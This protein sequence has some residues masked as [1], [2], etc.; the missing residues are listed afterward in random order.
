LGT[1]ISSQTL[2]KRL[3]ITLATKLINIQPVITLLF[4]PS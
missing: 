4:A 3:P 1:D 2:K